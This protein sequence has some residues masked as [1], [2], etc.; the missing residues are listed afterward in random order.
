M[1]V[2]PNQMP[3]NL[4]H[5]FIPFIT[6]ELWSQLGYGTVGKFIEDSRLKPAAEIE[7]AANAHLFRT[8]IERLTGGPVQEQ[9]A[10]AVSSSSSFRVNP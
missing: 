10:S 2:I 1:P 7:A 9:H 6:E 3:A 4:L 8:E 5:P